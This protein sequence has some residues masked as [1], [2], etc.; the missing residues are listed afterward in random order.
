MSTSPTGQVGYEILLPP[1]WAQIPLRS[2]TGTALEA[3]LDAATASRRPEATDWREQMATQLEQVVARARAANC[4][5]LYLPFAALHGFTVAASMSVAEVA[6][7]ALDPIDP[8]ELTGRLATA[9]NG[10]QLIVGGVVATR[11][12]RI[13]QADPGRGA[14][15]PSRQVDHFVPFPDDPDRWLVISFSA[16]RPADESIVDPSPEWVALFDAVMTTFRWVTQR[17]D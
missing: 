14:V 11:T 2:G 16:L 5:H 6:F 12:E 1:G 8:G 13:C 9:P 3:I 10:R 7:G 4:V 17:S 15:L